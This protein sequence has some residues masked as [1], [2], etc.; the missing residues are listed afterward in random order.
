MTKDVACGLVAIVVAAVYLFAASG[1]RSSPLGDSVG[2][3]GFPKIIGWGLAVAGL[4]LVLQTLWATL[5]GRAAAGAQGWIPSEAFAAGAGRATLRAAGVVAI[6]VA[7]LVLL[8]P[9]GYILSVG[10][11][12]GAVALYLG[13]PATWRVAAMAAI[14]GV[15]LWLLFV[16]LLDIPLPAGIT[17]GWL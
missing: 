10:L 13:T 17:A 8:Q 7:Y 1:L 14:G 15:A 5:R 2:S 6:V 4:L 3:A 16:V 11:M 9:L 12:V